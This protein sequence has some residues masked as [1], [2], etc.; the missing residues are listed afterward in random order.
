MQRFNPF[1]D[2][3]ESP[4]YTVVPNFQLSFYN[5]SHEPRFLGRTRE[6]TR[7]GI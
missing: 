5:Q 3:G 6:K 1:Q 2:C 7:K 4:H